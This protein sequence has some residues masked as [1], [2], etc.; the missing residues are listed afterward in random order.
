VKRRHFAGCILLFALGVSLA[1]A[2]NR[3]ANLSRLVVV[4][5]SLS[6]G[7]QNFS[8]LGTQQIHNYASLVAGQA[9]TP[10]VLPLVRFPGVPNVFQ[11]TSLS[12]L[13]IEPVKAPN[14]TDPVDARVDPSAIPTNLAVPGVFL[15]DI[16]N[17]RPSPTITSVVDFLTDVV[18][19]VPAGQPQSQVERVLSMKPHPTTI[20]FWAGNNDA[21]FPV[22][23]GDFS[24]LTS[25]A[26]FFAS[27]DAIMQKL[28][29]AN[30]TL[31][32]A[33]IPDVTTVPYLTSAETI[34][35]QAHVPVEYVRFVLGLAPGD[36]IRPAAQR[37]VPGIL[38][39]PGTG[40]LPQ[41]CTAPDG[42]SPVLPGLPYAQVPCV[43][44]KF[45]ADMIRGSVATFNAMIQ[46]EV[47][48]RNATLVDVQAVAENLKNGYAAGGRCLT[49]DFLGGLITLDGI[50]P[51][52]TLHAIIA[53]EFIRTMNDNLKTDI[54][55]VSVEGV[56]KADPLTVAAKP[57]TCPAPP[58]Q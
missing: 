7:F 24:L 28:S 9:N 45:E 54:P 6:A 39:N 47:V 3:K 1:P 21:L 8:L 15:A 55:F 58:I 37:L 17:K 42:K 38:Q 52:N 16:L 51:T 56:A 50:H 57:G 29:G 14:I 11:L 41:M 43:F 35:A 44:R 13:I 32:V 4:G 34:A 53:N 36:T 33:N 27:L 48:L 49:F 31:V 10:L 20:F 40:P 2:Q 26:S 5:D 18:L 46:S 19:G 30:H 23:T 12:P 25:P 22:L